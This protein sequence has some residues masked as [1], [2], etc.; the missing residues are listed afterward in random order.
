[1][2]AEWEGRRGLIVQR[3]PRRGSREWDLPFLFN[4]AKRTSFEQ[5]IAN[6]KVVRAYLGVLCGG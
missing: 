5:L 4:Q 3:Y 2:T 6:G 1:M